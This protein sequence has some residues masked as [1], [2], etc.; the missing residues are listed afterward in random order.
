M[1]K[2][3]ISQHFTDYL[4]TVDPDIKWTSE[5]ETT[6]EVVLEAAGEEQEKRLERS[7][8]FLDTLTVVNK[9]GQISTRVYRKATHT[10][11]YLN[12]TSNH[13]L[14]HKRGVV[15]TLMYRADSVVSDDKEKSKEKDHVKKALS[16]NGYPEWLFKD[17]VAKKTNR[18][19]N[20][21]TVQQKEC[22]KLPVVIPYIKGV[23]E[24]LRGAYGQFGVP[25]YFKPANT[26]RQLLVR[27]K[28]PLNKERVVGPVYH[29]TC[30]FDQ[31]DDDYIGETERSL[32]ARYGEHQRRSSTSS[33][34]SRHIFS[35]CPD[36]SISMDSTEILEVE[37]RWF[38]RGVKEAIHIR[39]SSRACQDS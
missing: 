22:K 10:D 37:P 21:N 20:T 1:L 4:N 28:D 31:C 19:K 24:K 2:K 33:E 6:T 32:K 14:E 17:T 3:A 30:E 26:L 5:G 13:P 15:N 16:V 12:F 8:A 18:S 11:Q 38:E 35:D 25:T 29:I 39:A 27:P 7:L 9:D 36:H 34:V 23:S